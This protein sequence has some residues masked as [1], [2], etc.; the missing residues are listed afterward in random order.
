MMTY[1]VKSKSNAKKFAEVFTPPHTVF[2]MILQPELR[3]LLA[4]VDKTIFDPA[5]GQ[6]QFP[7]CELVWKLFFNCD[8]LN[9]AIAL[10]ALESLYAADIQSKSIETAKTHMLTT[11]QAAYK[12]FSSEDF[13]QMKAAREIL[14]K[15]FIVGDSLQLMNIWTNPQLSL[16]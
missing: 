10:R 1:G 2:L 14:D 12:F 8:R 13:V 15:N 11:L 16:F 4:D 7:C 9:E 3:P 6:G 5:T